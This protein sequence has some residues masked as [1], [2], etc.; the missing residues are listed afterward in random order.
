MLLISLLLTAFSLC[1]RSAESTMSL[2][3]QVHGFVSK[4]LNLSRSGRES[5]SEVTSFL[6]R[7]IFPILLL[8]RIPLLVLALRQQI[9]LRPSP[10]YIAANGQL[11]VLSSEMGLTGQMVVAENIV[12]GYRFMRCNHSILGGRWIRQVTEGKGKR[13]EMGDSCVMR[14]YR[15]DE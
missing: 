8:L 1:I 5:L 7:Q 6:P 9:F 12:D 11:R 4:R 14:E 2:A 15:A 13:T 3:Q 10:P